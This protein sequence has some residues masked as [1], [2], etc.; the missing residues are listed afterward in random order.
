MANQLKDSEVL[1]KA[2]NKIVRGTSYICWAIDNVNDASYEQRFALKR[3]ISKMLDGYSSYESWLCGKEYSSYANMLSK[4]IRNGRIQWLN[5]MI[6]YCE[7]E[8]AEKASK[9]IILNKKSR[10]IQEL[11]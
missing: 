4:D 8:E 5:W 10:P 9:P 3:W 6:A 7:K 1:R 11:Q 2:K